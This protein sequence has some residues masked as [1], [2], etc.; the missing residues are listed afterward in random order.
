[1]AV[2]CETYRRNP[3]NYG[4]ALRPTPAIHPP[5]GET[6][7]VEDSS[8]KKLYTSGKERYRHHDTAYLV[9]LCGRTAAQEGSHR[10]P[11]LVVGTSSI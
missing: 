4:G 8:L 9:L 11:L 3:Q 5:N 2:K 7:N 6:V 10:Q 1:M